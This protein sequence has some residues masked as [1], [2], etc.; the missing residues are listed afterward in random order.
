VVTEVS[1]IE[2]G[3]ERSKPLF[4]F[5]STALRK[6][7]PSGLNSGERTPRRRVARAMPFATLALVTSWMA[8]L[9]ASDARGETGERF[10][11]LSRLGR[12]V[13]AARGPNAYVA[14]RQLWLEWNQGDPSEVEALLSDAARDATLAPPVRAYAGLLEAYARRRRGDLDG[15][16]ARIA[17]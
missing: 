5:L 6:L 17:N 13:R 4:K 15:A 11:R 2:A 12:D 8:L 9:A 14:L 3:A 16:R 10:E 1:R 7:V